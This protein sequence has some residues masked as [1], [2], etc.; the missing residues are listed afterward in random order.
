MSSLKRSLLSIAGGFILPL[1]Y[2]GVNG[3]LAQFIQNETIK[4]LL[5]MPVTWTNYI[6]DYFDPST[7]NYFY[8]PTYDPGWLAAF[9]GFEVKIISFLVGNVVLYAL[10]TYALLH[11]LGKSQKPEQPTV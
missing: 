1:L 4:R 8:T 10:V 5:I 7:D 6:Y 3:I 2:V 11:W 9:K